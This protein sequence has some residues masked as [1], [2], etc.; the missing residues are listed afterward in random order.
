LAVRRIAKGRPSSGRLA[1][2][3]Q[4]PSQ[5]DH[6]GHHNTGYSSTFLFRTYLLGTAQTHSPVAPDEAVSCF[7]SEVR[8]RIASL[9]V[10]TEVFSVR[11]NRCE[12]KFGEFAANI[13]TVWTGFD[14]DRKAGATG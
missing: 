3:G 2:E 4:A 13:H 9:D 14:R 1:F 8:D 6:H 10:D 5:E 7:A 11:L 12:G